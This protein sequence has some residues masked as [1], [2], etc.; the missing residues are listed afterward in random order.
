MEKNRVN[1]KARNQL[2]T[3][4]T[5]LV[6]A[7]SA[8]VIALLMSGLYTWDATTG[9]NNLRKLLTTVGLSQPLNQQNSVL[10]PKPA[11]TETQQ[12]SVLAVAGI[13]GV[14]GVDG[15]DGVP[16]IP[17][18]DGKAGTAGPIGKAGIAGIA[19]ALG[20]TGAPGSDGAAGLP[21]SAGAAGP[22]GSPGVAG[23]PGTAGLRG[24]PGTP[25]TPGTPGVQG[26]KGDPGSIEG[27][28]QQKFC[29]TNDPAAMVGTMLIGTCEENKVER[30]GTDIVLLMQNLTPPKG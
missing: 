24:L 29:V 8:L 14:P 5:S 15:H 27:Y 9:D 11:V 25:G 3:S 12:S 20:L 18:H 4:R 1:R 21:G 23:L 2:R 22:P 6:L 17:G 7:S 13:S 19:G 10:T 16:G 30:G 28:T 26:E